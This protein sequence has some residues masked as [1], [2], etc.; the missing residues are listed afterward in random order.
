MDRP[1]RPGPNDRQACPSAGCAKWHRAH[2]FDHV[3]GVSRPNWRRVF[4]DG[5]ASSLRG[6]A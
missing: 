2:G 5:G 4:G 6:A 1:K 3:C